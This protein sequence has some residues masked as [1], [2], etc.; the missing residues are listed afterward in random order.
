MKRSIL[1]GALAALLVSNSPAPDYDIVIRGGR[2]LDGA[3]NPWVRADVA[4]KDGRIVKVGR[5]AG[6]GAREIDAHDRYVTPGFIDMMDQSG[7]VLLRN[8]AAENKLREGVT[9]VIAGEGGTPVPAAGIRAYFDQLEQQGIAVN[10]GTYYAAMQARM[11]VMGDG[12]GTPTPGQ[13]AEMGAEV[14][15]AMKAG[16]FGISTALIYS[17]QTFQSTED[18][19]ALGKVAARCGGF[20]ATHMRDE[21]QNLLS[22]IA[23]AV[24]I[25]EESGAKVEIFHMKA[26][27]RPGW[28]KLMPQ[29]VQAIAAARARGVDV[30]ADMYVYTAGGTGIDITVPT[31]V[32]ADGEAK[33]IERLKDPA[34][35]ARLKHEVAAGSMPGWS[36]LVEASGGWDHVT[37]ANAFNPKYD[38]F[39]G[40]SFA[41]IGRALGQDPADAAWDI[42]LG[43]LP[44]RAYALYFMIDERDIETALRQPWL[45]IGSDAGAAERLG[46]VDGLGL[47]HPRAYGNLA[48]VLA[49]YWRKRGVL[50]LEDAV[51]KM[52]SWP[53]QRMGLSDRGLIREG[54]RAD[55]LVF[56]P[57]KV[58][59][60]ATYAQPVL[61]ATGI[62]DVI[63]NGK[64]TLDEGRMTATRAG[65]VLR[66][67]CGG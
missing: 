10:F 47:P 22:A 3:G 57:A 16:A 38:R 18:L 60:N 49:E 42:M 44:H 4:I 13:L 28:G 33:G 30:A 45:S 11:K 62:D 66:H 53:A 51:R 9:T 32:W 54:M 24:R 12:A 27:Y 55:V 15:T 7:A 64:L 67:F 14:D 61:V 56:D 46:Q 37:L 39:A 41:A 43:A 65:V 19:I 34:V 6:R 29:A 36:N 31:W 50:T 35:R 2:V 8:G 52:T 1:L 58:Q 20:Y 17:P 26:A 5:V 63:V 21:S 23:E 59:D 25:G 48:R 40:Q